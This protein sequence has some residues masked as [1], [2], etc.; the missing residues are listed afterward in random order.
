M[1]GRI[2]NRPQTYIGENFLCAETVE[3]LETSPAKTIQAAA[4]AV[5]AD[6]VRVMSQGR[7]D[8]AN[9]LYRAMTQ[10][11]EDVASALPCAMREAE[12]A[13]AR[14]LARINADFHVHFEELARDVRAAEAPGTMLGDYLTLVGELATEPK[15]AAALARFATVLGGSLLLP[16]EKGGD[17]PA[18]TS[19]APVDREEGGRASRGNLAAEHFDRGA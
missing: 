4:R 2:L 12:A 19:G 6:F 13:I 1:R 8:M 10:A 14:D 5:Q 17:A 15:K 9:T 3:R 18:R 7:E 11:Q 16:P